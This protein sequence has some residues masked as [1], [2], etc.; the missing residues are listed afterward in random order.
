[1]IN[2]IDDT[3]CCNTIMAKVAHSEATEQIK[4]S[5]KAM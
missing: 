1:M 5:G 2:H 4:F 3:M